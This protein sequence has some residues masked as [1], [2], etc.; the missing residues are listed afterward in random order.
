MMTVPDYA[1]SLWQPHASLICPGVGR[2]PIKTI[3]TRSWATKYRGP[4]L[5]CSAAKRPPHLNLP[6]YSRSGGREEHDQPRF[7][8]MDTITD[9]EFQGLQPQGRRIPNRAKTPTM[10]YPATG[11]HGR[12]WDSEAGTSATEQGTAIH[13]PLGAALGVATIVDC[14]PVCEFGLYPDAGL[15]CP[16]TPHLCRDDSVLV[17]VHGH[18]AA[19]VNLSDQLPYGDFTP[20]RYGDILEDIVS[21]A[22]PIAVKG[23]QRLWRTDNQRNPNLRRLIAEQLE[24]VE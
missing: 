10:F 1:L 6:P 5:I 2:E 23:G 14:L 19:G 16:K 4:V 21:F 9:P 22:E 8:V 20:G 15:I 7:L 13:L 3:E 24:S 18:T 11:P 17:N 12:S